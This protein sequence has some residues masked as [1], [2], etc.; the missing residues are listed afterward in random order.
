MQG[1]VN[2][3]AGDF[4]TQL[5][6]LYAPGQKIQRDKLQ[7]MIAI[8]RFGEEHQ[9]FGANQRR[10]Q[11]PQTEIVNLF[12][13][14]AI[15]RSQLNCNQDRAKKRQ[16]EKYAVGIDGETMDA[17]KFRKHLSEV[18]SQKSEVSRKLLQAIDY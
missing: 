6:K 8:L 5:G 18:R 12:F 17:E 1:H 7:R 4:V 15:A 2:G 13:W 11:H 14:Q 3:H 9:N 16:R 10:Q